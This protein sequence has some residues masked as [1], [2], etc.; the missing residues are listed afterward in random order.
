ML[1]MVV[2]AL[3][4]FFAAVIDTG[5]G[6]CYG[7]I[8]TPAL[9]IT[10]Y[11]PEVVVPTV[12]L[13]QLI[14]DVVGGITHTKVKNFTREDIKTALTVA[15]PATIF[16][17]FGAFSNINLPKTVTKTYIGV[18][19]ALLGVMMLLGIKLRKTPKR[20]MLISSLGGFNKGFM[21]GGFGPVVV[22]GQIVLN[23]DPR[24]SIPIGDIAEIPVVVF[25]LLTFAAFGALHFSPIFA[26]VSIPALI[27]S[28]LGPYLTKTI[29][30]KDY[31]EKVVGLVALLLGIYTLV[32]VL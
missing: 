18:L 11:S 14:V 23:H 28:F 13:S 4:A 19:V 17:V 22:S 9:L 1:D 29:A 8:L 32:E 27:A 5:L 21:G 12:L 20:L 26:I 25:G 24:P 30:E 16:V 15:V 3:A 10:G 31:A 2:I 6:M 7:T